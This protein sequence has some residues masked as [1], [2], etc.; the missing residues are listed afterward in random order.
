[1]FSLNNLSQGASKALEYAQATGANIAQNASKALDYAE[2]KTGIKIAESANQALDTV[3]YVTGVKHL[4]AGVQ[5]I[6]KGEYRNGLRNLAIG[7]M[8]AIVTVGTILALQGRVVAGNP[9]PNQTAPFNPNDL[10]QSSNTTLS[11]LCHDNLGI[12]RIQMP[13]VTGD[14]LKNFLASRRVSHI[15]IPSTDLTPIQSEMSLDK[16]MGMV[17]AAQAGKFDPCA[18]EI[19]VTQTLNEG[20]RVVDGH[21]GYA[22]CALTGGMQRAVAVFGDALSVLADLKKF[23]GVTNAVL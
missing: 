15:A 14:V 10:C 7:S 6:R 21:H 23:P 9:T 22:A 11:S 5:D 2:T 8:P 13:Q 12:P 16:I 1:M 4:M 17:N 18:R 20:V 19:L 3:A